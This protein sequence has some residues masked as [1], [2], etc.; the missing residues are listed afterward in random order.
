MLLDAQNRVFV[1]RR[2]DMAGD[3]WQMPPGR[4]RPRRDAGARRCAS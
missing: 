1:G 3:N 4:H 2:I